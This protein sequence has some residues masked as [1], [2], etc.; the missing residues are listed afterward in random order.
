MGALALASGIVALP[1]EAG[2]QSSASPPHSASPQATDGAP[3][4][5]EARSVCT[6]CH[7]FPPA[8]I[9]PRS[10]W[11]DEVTR[12]SLIRDN[13]ASDGGSSRLIALPPD[14]ERALRYFE[15]HAPERLRPPTKWP[16][17]DPLT[18]VTRGL[19]STDP[20][21]SPAVANVRL[22]DIDGDSRLELLSSDMRSG[23]ISLG[24]PYVG[25]ATMQVLATLLSP[26]HVSLADFDKNGITDLFVADLGRFLPSDHSDG[27][28]VLLRGTGALKY[29][30]LAIDGWPRVADVEAGDFDGNGTLDI[31]VAAFGWRT[32]GNISVLENRT[33]DYRHPSFVKHIIDPRPGAIHVIPADVNGDGRLDIVAVISQQFETVMAYVNDGTTPL[34]FTPVVIYTAPHPDWGCSGIQLVGLDGDHDLDVLLTHGDT[35]D[36]GRIKPDH[37][38][39]WLENRG[40]FPFI[41]HTLAELPGGSRAQAADLD[42]DGDLD[43]VASTLVALRSPADESKLPSLVWLEQKPG[44]NFERHTLEVGSPRHATLDVADFDEDGDLDIVVGNFDIADGRGGDAI[45]IWENHRIFHDGSTK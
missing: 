4:E 1:F 12:M 33:V 43:I 27:A 21:T 38:I 22:V 29:E 11:R 26:A 40:G 20:L 23:T 9:L 13:R 10:Q 24:R 42:G 2:A 18:F 35:L 34:S 41:E 45:T 8:D 25:D 30:T 3:T 36:I 31:V 32:T 37:G 7:A 39:Q 28:V 6:P 14:F 16:D 44:G 5:A 17:P 15:A 19:S